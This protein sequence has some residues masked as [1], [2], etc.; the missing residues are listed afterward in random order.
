MNEI[1]M[2]GLDGKIMRGKPEVLVEKPVLVPLIT[3]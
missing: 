2:W 1:C 3:T